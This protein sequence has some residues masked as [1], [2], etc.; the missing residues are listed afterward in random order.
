[1]SRLTKRHG[2]LAGAVLVAVVLLIMSASL[3]GGKV[4]SSGD[5]LFLW[6]P[7]SA[8]PP[9]GW[10]QPSNF[11]LTD[12][13]QGFIPN[14]LQ[15][16]ADLSHGVLPLWNPDVGGGR[17]LFA[18]QVDALLFPLTWLAF[19]LPFWSSLGWIA[20]AKLLLA[21]LGTYLFVRDLGLRRGPAL[22][23]ALA[24]ACG[25]FFVVWLE[26]PQTAVWLCLPWM[27]LGARGICWRGSLLAT[28]LLGTAT[29]LAWQGGHP[30]S[31]AFLMATTAAFA[32]TELTAGRRSGS[33]SAA[34]AD[35][36][37]PSW[38]RSIGARAGLVVAGLVLGVGVGAVTLAP[39]FELL[40]QA[41]PTNRGGPALSMSAV[42]SFV[43]P[44]LWG[45]PNKLFSGAGP[46]NFN[47]RTAYIGAL[48]ALLALGSLGRRRPR[49]VWFF[50]A[51]AVVSFALTFNVPLLATAIRKLPEANVARLT[52]FL[53]VLSFSAAVLAAYGLQRWL[54]GSSSDRRR[55]LTVM[56]IAAVIP[57]LVWLVGHSGQLG[58]LA[59]AL[60]Q[61][62]TVHFSERSAAV[63]K[64][65]SVWRWVLICALGL[66]GLLLVSRR[67]WPGIAAIVLV[68]A[69]TTV[70][71]V[72]LDRGYHGSIPLAQAD[73]PVPSSIYYLQ[74][75]QG[76]QRVVATD[77]ALP[78]NVGVRYGLRDARVGIDIPY[79][80]RF[81]QLWT[82]LGGVTGDLSFLMGASPPAHRLADI[83]AVR[84]ALVPPGAVQPRWLRT[85]ARTPG[86]TI[87]VNATALPRAWVAY[88][89]RRADDRARALAATLA[90]ATTALRD[91]PV[92]EG[93]APPP[94]RATPGPSTAKVVDDST[95]MVTV[96]AVAARSGY[97]VLDDSAY[98][99]W[100]ATLDGRPAP[101]HP[102][103]ENFRAVAV[104]AGRHTVVF[105][106]RPA[107]VRDGAIVSALSVLALIAL[108]VA[109]VV[110]WWRRPLAAEVSRPR[111]DLA[112]DRR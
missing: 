97:V 3:F 40:G 75:H 110:R 12:P 106:Y 35:W 112:P 48:P 99:G 77:F 107:S 30:E 19:V 33:G 72:T 90:S 24:F 26:H 66:G 13:V 59:A 102:A 79:P 82:G 78:A 6:A 42:W 56:T 74:L 47:E 109:G 27:L 10:V 95:D 60:G 70:D 15:A 11:L 103:N 50:T 14:M 41:G 63:V 20:A 53:I 88:D 89:W 98:P 9:A 111:G 45:M 25:M 85:V 8:H 31:A 36:P 101:W 29:G 23:A 18:S 5:N 39:L 83:F 43:F 73:P 52:R 7:F 100:Q 80:L 81:T 69:V 86:G 17:P 21:A 54:T 1:M 104:P 16:R 96:H 93:A 22:L 38:S 84:Y 46:V 51:L 55:M 32:A 49:E 44:E 65:A 76:E 105:R 37:G 94:T 62:P 91:R 67:R 92:I 68:L 87:A 28:A 64:L 57:P 58:H 61:L 2:P 34:T 108:L 4:F 71:L